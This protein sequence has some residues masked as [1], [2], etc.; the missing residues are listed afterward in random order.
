MYKKPH[1]IHDG[2]IHDITALRQVRALLCLAI[3][4]VSGKPGNNQK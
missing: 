1:L 2:S 4:V 3:A